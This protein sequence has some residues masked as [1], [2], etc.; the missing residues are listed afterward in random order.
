MTFPGKAT[1]SATLP[2]VSLASNVDMMPGVETA[3]LQP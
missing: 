1:A 3:V 2:F